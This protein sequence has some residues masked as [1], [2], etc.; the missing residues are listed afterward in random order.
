MET[1]YRWFIQRVLEKAVEM[2]RIELVFTDE[3][4]EGSYP[5]PEIMPGLSEIR[6]LANDIHRIDQRIDK[7]TSILIEQAEIKKK[8][9]KNNQMLKDSLRDN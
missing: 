2:G 5:Q 7:V 6:I 9:H 3:F 4:C 1:S 8:L